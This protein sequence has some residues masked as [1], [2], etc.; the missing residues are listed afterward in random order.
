MQIHE[1]GD[2][3]ECETALFEE[4]CEQTWEKGSSG[5]VFHTDD[6]HWDAAQGDFHERTADAL[7]VVPGDADAEND[8]EA[9]TE[10]PDASFL[11]S[12]QSSKMLFHGRRQRHAHG[13]IAAHFPP[14]LSYRALRF[15]P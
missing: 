7:D 11:Q 9:G 14:C 1:R 4:N 5:L 10:D 15:M 8:W 6:A 12:L 3:L 2:R 13:E